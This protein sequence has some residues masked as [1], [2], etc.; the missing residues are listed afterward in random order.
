MPPAASGRGEIPEQPKR[1]L[2]GPFSP[3]F[4]TPRHASQSR[5]QIPLALSTNPLVDYRFRYIYRVICIAMPSQ[6][7]RIA[8]ALLPHCHRIAMAL[9]SQCRRIATATMADVDSKG[10][11]AMALPPQCNSNAVALPLEYHGTAAAFPPQCRR[12]PAA[13]PWHCR[14]TA[15]PPPRQPHVC[16]WSPI[17]HVSTELVHP[18]VSRQTLCRHSSHRPALT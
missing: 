9:P 3:H 4:H 12:I 16:P 6:C 7:R 14:C 2:L 18:F 13:M 17:N 1:G 5:F 10:L 8:T 15:T 11:N